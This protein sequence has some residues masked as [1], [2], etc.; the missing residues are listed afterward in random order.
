MIYDC[1]ECA[2]QATLICN[3]CSTIT[4]PSGTETRPTQFVKLKP[5]SKAEKNAVTLKAYLDKGKPL[6]LA[7]VLEYN[8]LTSEE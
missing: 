1:K 2:N 7:I 6:P 3:V 8:E 5:F 4:K